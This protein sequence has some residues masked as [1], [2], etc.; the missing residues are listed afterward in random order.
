M[1]ENSCA[2]T[3]HRMLGD[4]FDPV[5]LERVVERLL[6]RGVD[7]FY[8]GMAKGFDL[9]AAE[10][11]LKFKDRYGAKLIC[12]IPYS[13]QADYFSAADKERYENILEYCER[14]IVFSEKYNRWCMHARDRFMAENSGT[15]VCYLRRSAGGTYYTVKYAR[16]LG[17]KIIEI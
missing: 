1:R 11:V 5:L 14:K 3:G 7:T 8:C 13:G 16:S 12:C 9:F 10:I 6:K 4:D 15:V 2:F 17:D